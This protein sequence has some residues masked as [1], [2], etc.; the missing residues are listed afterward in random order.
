MTVT[1]G[2]EVNADTAAGTPNAMSP[3]PTPQ[4][5]DSIG[6]TVDKRTNEQTNETPSSPIALFTDANDTYPNIGPAHDTPSQDSQA[7]CRDVSKLVF[8][9]LMGWRDS[10]EENGHGDDNDDDSDDAGSPASSAVSQRS[11]PAMPSWG[12]WLFK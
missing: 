12:S 10:D 7:R 9:D 11:L 1:A 6:L 5:E 4:T 8:S 3:S 2:T